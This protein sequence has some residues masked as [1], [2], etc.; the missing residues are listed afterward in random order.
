MRRAFLLIPIA[1]ACATERSGTTWED[2]A[3]DGIPMSARPSAARSAKG[4]EKEEKAVGIQTRQLEATADP[5]IRE[6]ELELALM[7]FGAR[8][9][10]IAKQ[11]KEPGENGWPHPLSAAF[12]ELFDQLERE[13]DGTEGSVPRRILIQARVTIEVE[14]ENA[15]SRHGAPPGDLV[16]RTARL[17]GMIAMHMRASKPIAEER[18]R[19]SPIALAWPV[20]PIIV[21]SPFGYRRDPILGHKTV[22]FHAGVDLGGETGEPVHSA[23]G[24][25]VVSAGWLG[26]HG[27]TVILQHPG[28]YQTIYAHLRQILVAAGDQVDAGV[29]VG[30]MGSSGRSTGPHLHFEVRRGGV[31]LDPLDAIGPSYAVS[32]V[33]SE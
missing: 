10:Q 1:C 25:R 24:G 21:T 16:E 3:R 7:R 17:Y 30:L 20:S 9:R 8:R 28:G 19:A 13:L 11:P 26:G 29:P 27:R 4:K 14:L 18:R 6:A 22:R 2:D 23:A 5:E 32:A 15:Q 33:R 12:R 31:P